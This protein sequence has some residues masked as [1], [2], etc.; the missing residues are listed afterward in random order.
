MENDV[1]AIHLDSCWS[2]EAETKAFA[3]RLAKQYN[4][5][6]TFNDGSDHYSSWRLEGHKIDLQKAVAIEWNPGSDAE[7][8]LYDLAPIMDEDDF[9]ALYGVEKKDF[10]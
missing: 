2:N 10:L 1:L 4:V 3:E 7:A 9:R 8:S 6:A 5:K